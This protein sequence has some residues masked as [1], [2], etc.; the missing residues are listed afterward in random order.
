MIPNGIDPSDLLAVDEDEIRRLRREFAEHDEKL[1]MLVG[2]LV[3]C[4]ARMGRQ[5]LSLREILKDVLA[6]TRFPVVVD[7]PFGHGP[8]SWTLPIGYRAGMDTGRGRVRF[9][10]P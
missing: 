7:L 5:T 8:G 1:V 2:R 3:G 9:T 10:E 6:G 4:Q